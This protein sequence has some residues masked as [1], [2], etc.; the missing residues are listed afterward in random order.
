MINTSLQIE[1]GQRFPV[2]RLDDDNAVARV[3][4]RIVCR[5][6]YS[7]LLVEVRQ[8]LFLVPDVVAG[9]Q[10]VHAP[11]EE[12]VGHLWRYAITRRRVLA[13]QNREIDG[14]LLLQFLQE[15]L[16]IARPARGDGVADI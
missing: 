11:I 12:L 9:R 5:P 2:S 13:I 1:H 10:D 6:Q 16:T 8:N 3:S 7:R 4:R 14:V 15:L